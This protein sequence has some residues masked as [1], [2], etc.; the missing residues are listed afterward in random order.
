MLKIVSVLF[1]GIWHPGRGL[2]RQKTCFN[3]FAAHDVNMQT[4]AE[5][6]RAGSSRI[7]CTLCV[8]VMKHIS[9][10]SGLHRDGQTSGRHLFFLSLPLSIR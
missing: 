5:G 1:K 10:A 7:P 2:R 4:F 3:E 9:H 8:S 6:G